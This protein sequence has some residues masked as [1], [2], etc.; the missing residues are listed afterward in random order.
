MTCVS[1]SQTAPVVQYKTV[2]EV[3]PEAFFTPVPI[4]SR[5][6][7]TT[8]DLVDQLNDTTIAFN[9][10]SVQLMQGRKWREAA[11]TETPVPVTK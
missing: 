8:R 10:C 9:Q 5:P 6:L 2:K 3:P 11:L 1:C 7:N 4:N